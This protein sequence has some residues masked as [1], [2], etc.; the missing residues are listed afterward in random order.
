MRRKTGTNYHNNDLTDDND[1]ID[2]DKNYVDWASLGFKLSL[3]TI[4]S[5]DSMKS[6]FLTPS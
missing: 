3:A 6:F 4:N 5:F 2:N 1:N